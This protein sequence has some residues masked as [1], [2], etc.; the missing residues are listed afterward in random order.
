MSEH[1]Q[2]QVRDHVYDGI[3]EYDNRLPNW[4]L[5][6]LY[7]SIVFAV[8]YWLVFHTFG[9]GDLQI[10][11]YDKEM[12]AATE[13]QLAAMAG[14]EMNDDALLMIATL[15]ERVDEGRQLFETYCVVCHMEQGQGSVGPNLTDEFWIHGG[16]PMAIHETVTDGVLSKGMAAWGNQLGPKRVQSV[17]GYVLT[18]KNTNVP[19]KAPEGEPEEVTP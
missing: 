15:P 5:F 14:M 11:K 4:W 1:K 19:G 16:S 3:Q 6:I 13:A 7:A 17:V 10:A 8:G 18:L 12:I 9:V 2:D